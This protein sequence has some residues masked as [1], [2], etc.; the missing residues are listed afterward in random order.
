MWSIVWGTTCHLPLGKPRPSRRVPVRHPCAIE[1]PSQHY[2]QSFAMITRR[3]PL[4]T[5]PV[6]RIRVHP[7]STREARL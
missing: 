2:I 6:L 3:R 4:N 5:S 1:P 7:F